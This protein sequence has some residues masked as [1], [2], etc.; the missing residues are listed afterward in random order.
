M[1]MEVAF[2]R[3]ALQRV[4]SRGTIRQIM[5]A[6]VVAIDENRRGVVVKAEV[7]DSG[8]SRLHCVNADYVIFCAAHGNEKLARLVGAHSPT[9]MYFLNFMLHVSL[10][11][12]ETKEQRYMASVN[13]VLQGSDGGMYACVVPPTDSEPGLAAMFAP[14]FDGSY[15]S[16]SRANKSLS[17]WD[18]IIASGLFSRREEKIS[19]VIS[20]ISRLNPFL[21]QYMADVPL[22]SHRVTIGS[23]FNPDPHDRRVR[24][25]AEP[26]PLTGNRRAFAMTSPK[27]TTSELAGLTMLQHVMRMAAPKAVLPVADSGSG[28]G[29]FDLDLLAVVPEFSI[30]DVRVDRAV[31]ESY[32]ASVGL[33]HRVLPKTHRLFSDDSIQ[34]ST[35]G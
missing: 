21:R 20:R 29:P 5:N 27:W 12:C 31:A 23:G 32:L 2:K 34:R 9:G 1:A 6:S 18:E 22:E 35:A 25:L 19:A 8:R 28:F 26:A 30:T 17:G 15:I 14:G 10:P 13:F 33:P 11:P 4:Q 16:K 3:A 24:R 7:L